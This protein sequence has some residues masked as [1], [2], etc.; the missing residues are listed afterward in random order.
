M[1]S[2]PKDE[3]SNVACLWC[4][5]T[6]ARSK[7]NCQA[8]SGSGLMTT[9]ESIRL[10]GDLINDVATRLKELEVAVGRLAIGGERPV[11][12]T[13]A[14]QKEEWVQQF[15]MNVRRSRRSGS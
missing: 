6:G 7:R 10:L 9:E 3:G 4:G 12:D 13:S 2:T 8:C 5:G 1:L 15:M 14:D 11:S